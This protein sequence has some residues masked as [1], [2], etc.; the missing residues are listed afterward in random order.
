MSVSMLYERCAK[1]K[2]VNNCDQKRMAACAYLTMPA[3][4][5]PKP[6]EITISTEVKA[7]YANDIKIT[8]DYLDRLQDKIVSN[9]GIPTCYFRKETDR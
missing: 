8:Q 1:C 9:F 4:T 6:L 7:Y 5:E 3:P 2:D